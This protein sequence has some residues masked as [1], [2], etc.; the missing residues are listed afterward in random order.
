MDA[1]PTARDRAPK[2][3]RDGYA[4]GAFFFTERRGDVARLVA[5]TPDVGQLGRLI[6]S[7]LDRFPRRVRVALRVRSD[8]ASDGWVRY[9]GD[10]DVDTVR[11]A[12][13]G[14]AEAALED[15]DAE[16]AIEADTGERLALDDVG[17]LR[18]SPPSAEAERACVAAGLANRREEL[19]DRGAGW[20]RIVAGEV[21]QRFIGALGVGLV[22]GGDTPSMSEERRLRLQRGARFASALWGT[23]GGLLV[24]LGTNDAVRGVRH[25]GIGVLAVVAVAAGAMLVLASVR[26]GLAQIRGERRVKP[27]VA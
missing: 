27:D 3:V 16:L 8:Q 9:D 23:V 26:G 10:C 22:R 14:H 1:P 21:R 20:R 25:R 18:L 5:W 4:P 19:V 24:G 17:V 13:A 11:A 2:A 12:L 15:G 6:A 7:L